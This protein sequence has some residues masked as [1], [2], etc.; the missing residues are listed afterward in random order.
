M[1]PFQKDILEYFDKGK[2]EEKPL[3]GFDESP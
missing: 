2:F 1:E 3:P